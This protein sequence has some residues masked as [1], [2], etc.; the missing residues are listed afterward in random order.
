M[1]EYGSE[2]ILGRFNEVGKVKKPVIGIVGNIIFNQ[3]SMFLGNERAYVNNN[4]VEAV[5][6]AGGVPIILPII[7]DKN[8]IKLQIENI[9]GLVISGGYDVNPLLY[10][11]EPLQKLGFIY[12]ERDE[13]DVEV[14]KV[15]L[16][17]GKPILGICRGLQ[18]LNVFFGGTLYQ[19]LSLI[20]E[21]YINHSQ[22]SRPDA[23]GHTVEIVKETMLFNILGESVITNSFHHQAIKELGSG[24]KVSAKAKD[25]II[26]GIEAESG[27]VIGVQWHPEML[28]KKHT[29]MLKLFK[30][31]VKRSL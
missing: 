5:S 20:D 22:T 28:A 16:E 17:L 11:E 25:G 13:Y 9:D 15:A 31:L 21:C 23:I 4:Y 1:L 3:E 10:N 26:E 2:Y 18:I 29:E 7:A 27:F 24:L 14:I 30:A 12:P 8:T 6:N 19:D